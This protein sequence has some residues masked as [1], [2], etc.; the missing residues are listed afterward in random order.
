[1]HKERGLM[2]RMTS[3]AIT[4]V[5]DVQP[6][7]VWLDPDSALRECAAKVRGMVLRNPDRFPEGYAS[8]QQRE[9]KSQ[10]TMEAEILCT[11]SAHP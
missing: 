5:G 4:D 2:E 3:L 1:M 10:P 8:F 11:H 7:A 6:K 9:S